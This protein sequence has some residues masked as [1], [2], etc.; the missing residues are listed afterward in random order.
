MWC[1]CGGFQKEGRK[2][3]AGKEGE[4]LHEYLDRC[5][6]PLLAVESSISPYVLLVLQHVS[7]CV[8]E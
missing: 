5:R 4:L 2:N 6:S 3:E 1:S 7:V 8:Y